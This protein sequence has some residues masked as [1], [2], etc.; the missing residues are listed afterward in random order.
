M[1]GSNYL[2]GAAQAAEAASLKRQAMAAAAVIGLDAT[3][4]IPDVITPAPSRSAPSA[5]AGVAVKPQE[6]VS[7]SHTASQMPSQVLKQAHGPS[8]A[9]GQ[10]AELPSTQL[11]AHGRSQ[12]L[13]QVLAQTQSLPQSQLQPQLQP[14]PQSQPQSQSLQSDS[15]LEPDVP[16]QLP[17]RI[18]ALPQLQLQ[19]GLQMQS[20]PAVQQQQLQA[21]PQASQ[22]QQQLHQL[23]PHSS[24]LQPHLQQILARQAAAAT[25]LAHPQLQQQ[26]RS[27]QLL[28]HHH[29]SRAAFDSGA[30][31][32]DGAQLQQEGQMQSGPDVSSQPNLL[33]AGMAQ[34]APH[35]P[36][37]QAVSLQDAPKQTQ[38]QQ[39]EPPN[40]VAAL[41]PASMQFCNG[42]QSVPLLQ[43][44]TG[45]LHLQNGKS[46]HTCHTEPG[47]FHSR[48]PDEAAGY[49]EPV[50]A[51]QNVLLTD[52][53]DVSNTLH[54]QPTSK[55]KQLDTLVSG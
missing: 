18:D 8:Q 21:Q 19:S 15:Q 50:C 23:P 3:S 29:Q 45:G 37:T 22:W 13:S 9:A 52:S 6:A 43:P 7:Q 27:G 38:S 24:A 16:S 55:A 20:A 36:Q 47:Q 1:Q 25:S 10:S 49:Q 35:Q 39:T 33:P 51:T 17:S 14:D 5:T 26:N 32:A 53:N 4:Q 30:E 34:T 2:S 40:E 44:Q 46:Y 28:S 41:E 31:L 12:S 48:P 11:P 54:A 42:V